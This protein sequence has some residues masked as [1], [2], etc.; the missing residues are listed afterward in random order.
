MDIKT[1]QK[2]NALEHIFLLKKTLMNTDKDDVFFKI[3]LIAAN[4]IEYLINIENFEQAYDLI[5]AI[6]CLPEILM[7]A[8]RDMGSYWDL[9]IL[10]YQHKWN[11]NLFDELKD[12]ILQ[13]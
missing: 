6:H 8:D 3:I 5:D 13:L 4:Q 1:F 11:T 10:K 2:D 7:T 9:Y 12:R